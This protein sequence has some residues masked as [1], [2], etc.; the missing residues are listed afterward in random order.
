MTQEE[1]AMKNSDPASVMPARVAPIGQV[2]AIGLLFVI[3]SALLQWTLDLPLSFSWPAHLPANTI[4]LLAGAYLMINLLGITKKR[5]TRSM[6]WTG[7]VIL[8]IQWVSFPWGNRGTEGWIWYTIL[9]TSSICMVLF[10][11]ASTKPWITMGHRALLTAGAGVLLMCCSSITHVTALV[12]VVVPVVLV[13]V[14]YN[15]KKWNFWPMADAWLLPALALLMANASIR[16]VE[17]PSADLPEALI[18]KCMVSVY[19][20]TSLFHAGKVASK[21]KMMLSF[22]VMLMTMIAGIWVYTHEGEAI[23]DSPSYDYGG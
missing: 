9:S 23:D 14:F 11:W 22:F 2:L 7:F 16:F 12:A 1:L 21:T 4:F 18:L 15:L 5:T 13:G 20:C 3:L 10:P 6:L 17:D 8:I 19:L